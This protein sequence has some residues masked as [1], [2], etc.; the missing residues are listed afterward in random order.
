MATAAQYQAVTRSILE[1]LENGAVPW[2]R[3]W[4]APTAAGNPNLN[5]NAVTG[6]QYSGMNVLTLWSVAAAK[7]Y[8]S[9]AWLT[10]NQAE[11]LGGTVKKG[12]KSTVVYFWNVGSKDILN[13][14]TGKVER[15]QTFSLVMYRVF[16]TEQTE[17][18]KFPVKR[19]TIPDVAPEPFDVNE[20]AKGVVDN[21]VA[22]GGPTFATQAQLR[23]YYRP[24]TDAVVVPTMEQFKNTGSAYSTIFHELGHSTGHVSRLNR[25]D[26]SVQLAAFGSEDYSK[27]ELIAELTAAFLSAETGIDNTRENSVAYIANWLKVLKDDPRMVMQASTKAQK[28][29]NLILAASTTGTT[30]DQADDE[31]VGN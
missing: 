19:D 23:A 10:F 27:E 31:E 25:F 9:A 22:N 14:D 24:D 20:L 1:A 21:Y 26:P 4:K 29:A 7:G 2:Q 3:P 17:G 11:K 13:P 18:C 16:N 12:E 6:R 15:K 30:P 8:Q 5:H 28:A